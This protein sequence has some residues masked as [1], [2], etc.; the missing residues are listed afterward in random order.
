MAISGQ[1]S[2]PDVSVFKRLDSPLF[3]PSN[4]IA[5]EVL[6]LSPKMYW[7]K[8][9]WCINIYLLLVLENIASPVLADSLVPHLFNFDTEFN[10]KCL[11]T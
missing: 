6:L 11:S 9:T 7:G 10:L 2:D 1:V 8:I 3:N 4:S 5:I